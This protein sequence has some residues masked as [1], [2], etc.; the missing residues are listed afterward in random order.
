MDSQSMTSSYL[1]TFFRLL[2][3]LT[4]YWNSSKGESLFFWKK[5]VGIKPS[6]VS[7]LGG[8][9]SFRLRHTIRTLLEKDN[10]TSLCFPPD[11]KEIPWRVQREMDAKEGDLVKATS[12]GGGPLQVGWSASQ[13]K[14]SALCSFWQS[15]CVQNCLIIRSWLE[16][17]L[18]IQNDFKNL[19]S[20]NITRNR[21]YFKWFQIDS[22]GLTLFIRH[23][24]LSDISHSSPRWD[25]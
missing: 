5:A 1:A 24:L 18:V 11:W 21:N 4:P 25:E 10:L 15:G 12:S 19:L 6:L 20:N 2:Y 16:K 14:C 7:S 23:S 13:E 8:Y 22:L 9:N 3:S 17:L